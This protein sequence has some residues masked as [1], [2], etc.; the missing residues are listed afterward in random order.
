M[1]D[2]KAL[3]F[4]GERFT[5]ECDGGIWY[6]HWHRYVFVSSLAQG[7]QVLDAACGEGYGSAFLAQSAKSVIGVDLSQEAIGHARSRYGDQ[8]NL[9][10][11]ACSVAAI[12]VESQSV[13]LIV[14]FETIEHLAQQDEMLREF[15]RILRP[16][17]L[18][19]L[20][21]PN[22]PVYSDENNYRNEY[23]VREM[24]RDELDSLVNAVFPRCSW[25]GQR[26]LFH[27][28]IWPQD[29]PLAPAP[30]QFFSFENGRAVAL[31]NPSDAM[32]FL[33]FCGDDQTVLPDTVALSLFADARQSVY[34]EYALLMR[35]QWELKDEIARLKSDLA[36]LRKNAAS[37][38]DEC[39]RLQ[40]VLADRINECG[41]AASRIGALQ[42]DIARAGTALR[43][44]E[45]RLRYRESWAGWLRFPLA[46][47]KRWITGRAE[48]A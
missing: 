47:L 27:S 37:S 10:F 20:S 29:V 3:P 42:N 48:D 28:V 46:R 35:Q 18:L 2:Q 40:S 39:A 5:P 44:A 4:T 17:G 32:Y 14:S 34:R 13:D 7:R 12:P 21:S 31:K 36:S 30:P 9:S 26:L 15:R 1:T 8:K 33:L 6:E 16:G 19:V 23:H 45:A 25:Y 41:A 38:D 43:Q 24:D 11:Q 22:R